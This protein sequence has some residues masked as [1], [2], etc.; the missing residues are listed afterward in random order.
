M[1]EPAAAKAE[2]RATREAYGEALLE[3]GKENKD[4]V[5]LDADLSSSTKTSVFAKAF[6]ER[7]FN[8]GVSEQDLIGTAAGLAAAGKIPFASTF[9]LFGAGRA[10]EQARND[11]GRGNLNVKMAMTH[12]GITVGEDGASHQCNEDIAIMRVIP[13]F[14]IVSPADAPEAKK[15]VFAAAGQKGP[16]YIRLGRE[17]VP[18]MGEREFKLGK[19]QTLRD[20]SDVAIMATGIMVCEALQAAEALSKEGVSAMVVNIHTIKPIDEQ[21]V[22]EAAKKTG[23]VV[24]AEEHS[25]IGGLGGAVAEVLSENHAVPLKRVGVRDVFG[26]SGKARELLEKYGLTAKNI[27]AAAKDVVKRK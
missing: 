2:K 16:F 1:T 14:T 11:V 9:A 13:N 7:F 17:A 22:V 23:A 12:A 24:T 8:L 6:P 21:A 5:V 25:I 20:G 19:A 26:E 10:W 18:V 4:I 3:L 15:A 27:A